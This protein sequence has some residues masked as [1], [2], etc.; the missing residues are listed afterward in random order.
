MDN[1][2]NVVGLISSAL[3]TVMFI[4]QVVHVYKTEDTHAINYTFL[5]INL[6]ASIM[7]LIFSV[8]YTVI[9]MIIANVSAGMFSVSLISLKWLKEKR[10]NHNILAPMV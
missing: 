9:P 8:Y 6:L 10:V 4:P 2:V 7:A 1:T 3:I 5:L